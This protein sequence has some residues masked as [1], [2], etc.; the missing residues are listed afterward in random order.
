MTIHR[1]KNAMEAL[2]NSISPN[3]LIIDDDP[4]L[5]EFLAKILRQYGIVSVRQTSSIAMAYQLLKDTPIH[6]VFLDIQLNEE[7]GL[8]SLPDLAKSSP[9]S[10][11]V[12]VSAHSSLENAKEAVEKGARGFIVKPFT[13]QKVA[14]VLTKLKLI[15]TSE[16]N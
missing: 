15:A 11:F 13:P 2:L 14:G 6:L 1:D 3:V 10:K 16:S 12:M 5:R 8:E 7:N 4:L 9:Q